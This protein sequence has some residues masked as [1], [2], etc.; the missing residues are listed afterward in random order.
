MLRAIAAASCLLAVA[1]A[2]QPAPAYLQRLGLIERQQVT[3]EARIVGVTYDGDHFWLSQQGD[4]IDPARF[5]VIDELGAP[6]FSCDQ[7]DVFTEPGLNDIHWSGTW[8]WGSECWWLRAYSQA[9]GYQDYFWAPTP[10]FSPEDPVRAISH[11]ETNRFWVA[12]RGTGVWAGYWDGSWNSQPG[13]T[14]IIPGP[15]PGASGLAYDSSRDC[16]WLSDYVENKLYQFS[17]EG[18][19]ALAE[20]PAIG[21]LYGSPR[22]C[23]MAE[24]QRFGAVLGM[25]FVD[26]RG[27]GPGKLVLF[28]IDDTPVEKRTWGI[29]KALYR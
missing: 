23:C 13:W 11:S 28:E 7:E 19:P 10:P 3:I 1:A 20:I 6:Q 18:G 5:I 15:F 22:G 24:T 26:E 9:G 14:E 2:P 8:I 27:R 29:I 17:A 25:V 4:G 16:L 12:G 21:A